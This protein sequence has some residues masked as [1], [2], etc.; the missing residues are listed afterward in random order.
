LPILAAASAFAAPVGKFLERK[1]V[2]ATARVVTSLT[3]EIAA[4]RAVAGCR[5][6]CLI[7][8]QRC[9]R[10]AGFSRNWDSSPVL[11]S[12]LPNFFLSHKRVR[13]PGG[14]AAFTRVHKDPFEVG[15]NPIITPESDIPDLS[16]GRKR[17]L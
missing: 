13:V 16:E 6:I 3:L 7:F 14:Q 15:L 10:C 2:G 1:I 8:Y 4:R 5:T 17:S 11:M 12:R 9:K